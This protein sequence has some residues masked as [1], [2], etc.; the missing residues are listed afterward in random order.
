MLYVYISQICTCG[1]NFFFLPGKDV[2][3]IIMLLATRTTEQRLKI[4][5]E[6]EKKYNL[7]CNLYTASFCNF[8]MTVL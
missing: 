1:H 8:Q 4:K 7:V 3:V 6:Y 5:D 2:N